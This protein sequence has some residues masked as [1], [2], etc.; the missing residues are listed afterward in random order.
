MKTL[1]RDNTSRIANVALLA[2]LYGMVLASLTGCAGTTP[3]ARWAEKRQALTS[4]NDT[5]SDA[6]DAGQLTDRQTVD[7]GTV[8][9]MATTYL[10][11]AKQEL[12]EGGATFEGYLQKT[13]RIL[14]LMQIQLAERKENP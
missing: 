13:K 14:E 9:K 8:L 5:F 12:P 11:T 4:I 10:D 2:V 3:Q 7:I 6:V 1:N